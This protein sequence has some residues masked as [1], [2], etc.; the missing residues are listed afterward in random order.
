MRDDVMQLPW[1]LQ[2]FKNVQGPDA[3]AAPTNRARA[4]QRRAGARE[5]ID[6]E[7][8]Y[9]SLLERSLENIVP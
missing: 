4:T 7:F 1:P 2:S 9:S 5:D 8:L 6:V 3:T